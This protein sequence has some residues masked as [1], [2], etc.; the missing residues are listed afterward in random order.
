MNV[1]D[2]AD[3]VVAAADLDDQA[4]DR[5]QFDMDYSDAEVAICEALLATRKPLPLGLLVEIRTRASSWLSG[6]ALQKVLDALDR[7]ERKIA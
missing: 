6:A 1:V 4:R 7:Q 2:L 5:V 3:Q